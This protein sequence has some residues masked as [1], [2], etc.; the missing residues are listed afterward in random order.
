MKVYLM[1][2]AIVGGCQELHRGNYLNPWAGSSLF[3]FFGQF[4]TCINY[5]SFCSLTHITVLHY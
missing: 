5:T 4:T 2:N 3:L 1:V